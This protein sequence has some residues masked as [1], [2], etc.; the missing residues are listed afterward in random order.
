VVTFRHR[1][2]NQRGEA[3]M[4]ATIARMIKRTSA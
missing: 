3:V 1:V 2:L 4:E